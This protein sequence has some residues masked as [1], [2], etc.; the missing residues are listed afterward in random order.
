MAQKIRKL[1]WVALAACTVMGIAVMASASYAVEDLQFFTYFPTNNGDYGLWADAYNPS[2]AGYRALDKSAYQN[3]WFADESGI[4]LV[5]M[6]NG[7]DNIMFHPT[8][9]ESAALVFAAP[10]E[11]DYR[12]SLQF[13]CTPTYSGETGATT[14]ATI[15]VDN[16]NTGFLWSGIVNKNSSPSDERTIH[17]MASQI[18]VIAVDAQ[19]DQNS[20]LTQMRQVATVP[21]PA[22]VGTL[23]MGLV[24]SALGFIRRKK[25]SK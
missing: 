1:N 3:R 10:F 5:G 18:L 2:T 8:L 7:A 16:L 23:G 14:R 25:A 6:L 19:G 13:Y 9:N 15:F 22:S 12:Y 24:I 20:D 4:P 21:D 17:L 11:A